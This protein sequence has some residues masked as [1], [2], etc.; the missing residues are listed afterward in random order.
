M[1]LSL[2]KLMGNEQVCWCR[3]VSSL[4]CLVRE[5]CTCYWPPKSFRNYLR[6]YCQILASASGSSSFPCCFASP[7]GSVHQKTFGELHV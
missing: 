4:H 5:Q 1:P 7:C 2:T 6:T 3:D